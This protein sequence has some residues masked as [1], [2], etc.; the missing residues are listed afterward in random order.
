MLVL[1]AVALTPTVL[2]GALTVRR[3]RI[4]LEREVVRGNLALIRSVGRE[5]DRTLQDARGTLEVAAGA[6]AESPDD[7]GRARRLLTRVRGEQP[8]IEDLAAI[9][10]DSPRAAEFER[11]GDY[12]GY[13]SEVSF[14]AGRPRTVVVVQARGRTGELAGYLVARLDLGFVA[15]QLGTTRLGPGAEL[16]VIDGFGQLVA[17]TG[18][19]FAVGQSMR[20]EPA[21]RAVLA[22][23]TEGSTT[24]LGRVAVFRNLASFSE[25]RPVRWGVVLEQP[26][27]EAFALARATA[28][29]T[30]IVGAS[31]LVVALLLGAWAAARLSRP[32][33]ELADEMG[34]GKSGDELD[35]LAEQLRQLAR[36]LAREREFL[37]D[38]VRA[39]PVGVLSVDAQAVIRLLNPAQEQLS[40]VAAAVGRALSDVFPGDEPKLAAGDEIYEKR[41]IRYTPG[42][43]LRYRVRTSALR[44]GGYVIVQED[45]SDHARL[46]GELMRAEKLSAV[47]LL[48]AG[49]AHE[50]N[51]PLTTILGYAKLLEEDHPDIEPLK[52]IAEEA[53]RVQDI[54]RHLLD[55]S[56]QGP[57]QIRPSDLNAELAH[58]L[59]LVALELRARRIEV[60][61]E[62]AAALPPLPMDA[63]RLGQVFVNLSTNAAQ[64]MDGGGTLTVRTRAC[65]PGRVAVEFEDTGVGIPPDALGRVF[66]PFFTTK[67]PGV[68]TGLG[69][70]ISRQIVADHGGE[71]EVESRGVGTG[72]TFRVLLPIGPL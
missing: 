48:A 16:Y 69:L 5:L 68:G 58:T 36:G 20:A 50:I 57:G 30:A 62:F 42:A 1:A 4:D 11:T 39:L 46:E 13:T 27:S 32:L 14:A 12:G 17:H 47:G 56:R 44:G 51:N 60:K 25:F 55:F 7:A 29:T 6:W 59:K 66:E 54:I 64:A 26:A 35:A 34:I 2:L 28:R 38:V 41:V 23:P 18:R 71:M 15:A 21:A 37:E 40:Q 10:L 52:L 9:P 8:I 22:S 43:K 33:A 24:E 65:A 63:P 19:A 61:T 70:A 53:R 49:V 72:A 67:G 45:L 3:A 31:I